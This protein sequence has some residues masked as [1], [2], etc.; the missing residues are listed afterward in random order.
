M[1]ECF[2]IETEKL[3]G[4]WQKYK[5][6]LLRNYL[7]KDVE[8]PRINVQSILTRHWLVKQLFWKKFDEL[9]EHEIR[10][11]LVMNWLLKLVKKNIE[12]SQLQTI[13]YSL[14]EKQKDA[15][16]IE[17]P[18]YISDAFHSLGMPNYICDALAVPESDIAYGIIPEYILSTFRRIWKEMLVYEESERI[19]VLEPACGSANDFRF[20][21]A[22]GIA[23]FIDYRG[24]D[25]CD[26]NIDNARKMFPEINFTVGNVIEIK[27]GDDSFDFCFVHDLF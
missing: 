24:F 16:G 26:K 11:A 4:T 7:V 20:I 6:S 1:E 15:E 9:M 21:N 17:I 3:K 22:F 5:S 12:T 19:S 13:F 23:R 10:F 18:S 27:A 8:D 2:K 25:L 14:V